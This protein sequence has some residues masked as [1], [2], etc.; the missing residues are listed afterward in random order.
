MKPLKIGSNLP[1]LF[2]LN[3]S[4]PFPLKALKNRRRIV[5]NQKLPLNLDREKTYLKT[6]LSYCEN[7]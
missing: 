6:D 5:Q 4:S 2:F 3:I 1:S 7:E